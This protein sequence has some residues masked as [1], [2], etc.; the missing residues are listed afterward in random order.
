M[1]SANMV[2]MFHANGEQSY[3]WLS[4][5]INLFL[6]IEQGGGMDAHRPADG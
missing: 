4:P 2:N 1:A 3:T 6:K 5:L